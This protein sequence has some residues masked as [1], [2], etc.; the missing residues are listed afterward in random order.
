MTA[1]HF[2]NFLKCKISTCVSQSKRN[3]MTWA[4]A[5]LRGMFF[6]F[7][8]SVD[9]SLFSAQSH[10]A[11]SPIHGFLHPASIHS[12]VLACTFITCNNLAFVDTGVYSTW[13]RIISVSL[14]ALKQTS[15]YGRII[16]SVAE[17]A[18]AGVLTPEAEW[19]QEL[20]LKIKAAMLKAC[21]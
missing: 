18:L 7:S 20:E 6:W 1:F 21:W 2:C 5:P 12:C 8:D 16:Y 19:Q 10:S 3:K 11:W 17:V 4:P 14:F 9:F 13:H 15:L